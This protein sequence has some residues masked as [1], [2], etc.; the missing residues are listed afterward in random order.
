M[1][2]EVLFECMYDEDL[3]ECVDVVRML[4]NMVKYEDDDELV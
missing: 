4:I 1:Y 3:S 2:D